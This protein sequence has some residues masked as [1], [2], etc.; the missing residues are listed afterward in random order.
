M[1][2]VKTR[3]LELKRLKRKK[4]RVLKPKDIK[5]GLKVKFVDSNPNTSNNQDVCHRWLGEHG[6]IMGSYVHDDI[7]YKG[8][9]TMA[10]IDLA[11]GY[12]IQVFCNRLK[13]TKKDNG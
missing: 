3:S 1:A 13:K 5:I 8:C 7:S 12:Q 2:Y 4:N 11:S 6:I 9:S 10:I